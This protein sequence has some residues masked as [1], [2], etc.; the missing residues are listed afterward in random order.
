MK[1]KPKVADSLSFLNRAT[2]QVAAVRRALEQSMDAPGGE[3]WE[4]QVSAVGAEEPEGQER[5]KTEALKAR[6]RKL[7]DLFSLHWPRR[8]PK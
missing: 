3:E 5:P 6:E 2:G 7:R 1:K 8:K 4:D